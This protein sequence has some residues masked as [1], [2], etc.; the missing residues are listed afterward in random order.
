MD[1][2]LTLKHAGHTDFQASTFFPELA[3]FFKRQVIIGLNLLEQDW[4]KF[5]WAQSWSASSFERSEVVQVSV[6]LQETVNACGPSPSAILP[7][8]C[9]VGIKTGAGVGPGQRG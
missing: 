1:S 7:V 6:E 5:S 3:V 4:F 9:V 8:R 2:F